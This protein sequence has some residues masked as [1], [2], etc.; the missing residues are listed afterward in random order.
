MVMTATS[1]TTTIDV[2]A[3]TLDL[4]IQRLERLVEMVV[5]LIGEQRPG[6]GMDVLDDLREES[7]AIRASIACP[8]CGEPRR[9]SDRCLPCEKDVERCLR[10][11]ALLRFVVGALC[12]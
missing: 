1:G 6:E 12:A 3:T 10:S 11:G 5:L 9:Y 2:V 8:A 4:R 7:A